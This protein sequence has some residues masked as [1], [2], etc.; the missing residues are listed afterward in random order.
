MMSDSMKDKY[1]ANN[2]IQAM[3]EELGDDVPNMDDFFGGEEKK[4]PQEPSNTN[5][6]KS[7][8]LPTRQKRGN[9]LDTKAFD[10][11]L[12]DRALSLLLDY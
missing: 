5:Q 12:V 7:M 6:R 4:D 8:I 3:A 9:N 11:K 10:Q 1:N 2:N